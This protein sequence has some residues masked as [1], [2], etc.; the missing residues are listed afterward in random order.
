MS[1]F[2]A[3]TFGVGYQAF[4]N[5]G[6]PLSG[7]LLYTYLAGS[8]NAA[9]TYTDS[10]Q[11]T[12][13]ANPLVLNSAGRIPT[14]VWLTSGVQYKFILTD[15]VGNVLGTWDNVSGI[16]DSTTSISEWVASGLTPTYISATS[17]SVPGNLT[18]TLQVGRRLQLNV[19]GNTVYGYIASAVFSS[20]ITTLTMT[21]DPAETLNSGLSSFSYALLAG[22]NV[23]VPLILPQLTVTGTINGNAATA[24]QL[25]AGPITFSANS[26]NTV[27]SGTPT[28]L[29]FSTLAE[30]QEGGTNY[31]VSTGIFTAPYAGTYLFSTNVAVGQSS[32]SIIATGVVNLNYNGTAVTTRSAQIAVNGGSTNLSIVHIQKM[33][34]GDTVN[35]NAFSSGATC[36]VG[37]A[38]I[39]NT[40]NGT[41]L[42]P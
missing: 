18:A 8:T 25:A 21:M 3:P 41:Y 12:P 30:A 7:G 34:V 13:N 40:F 11:A 1:A 2:L 10:T 33:S 16:N 28:N 5:Q 24:T 26:A 42:C 32:S 23:S 27:T 6:Q 20:S 37:G 14:E 19:T 15:S 31:S 36:Q 4:N 39:Y 22:S 9:A 35:L 17:F 38:S 29:V